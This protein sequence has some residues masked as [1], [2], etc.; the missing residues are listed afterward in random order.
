MPST[1]LRSITTLA[2]SRVNSVRPPLAKMLICSAASE[3]LNSIVSKPAWP[4]SV[5]LSSPGF[6][7]KVSSPAPMNA[8]SLP[9]PPTI[10]SP[11]SPPRNMSLP[12]PPFMVSVGPSASSDE[13]SITSSPVRPFSTS[14]SVCSAKKMRVCVCSPKICTPPASPATP[15]TSAPCVALIVTVSSAPSTPPFGPRRSMSSARQSVPV[16]SPTT[17]LST[18]PS[19]RNSIRST[20]FRSIVTL[21]T[22]RKKPTRPP[23]A[24]MSMFSSALAPKNSIVSVPSW[25]SMVSLPSPGFHWNTSSPAPISAT[26][27]PLSP[28]MKSLPSPPRRVSAPWLPRIVSLPVPPSIVSFTTPAGSVVAVMPSLPPRP[29][30]TSESS[31]PSEP[32]TCTFAARPSTA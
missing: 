26:S 8:V 30:I 1:S 22:L 17:M 10:R 4:S 31:A 25:P 23:L 32:V 13:A 24:K 6:H 2:T 29:L 12:S 14:W 20:S 21:A 19:A 7:T 5:S 18:P 28:K 15:N 9:S 16:M 3:P 11:P 27:L